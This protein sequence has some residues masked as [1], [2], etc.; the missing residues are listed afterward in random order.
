MYTIT[1]KP[2][3]PLAPKMIEVQYEK[4]YPKPE[5]PTYEMK[6]AGG[7]TIREPHTPDTLE[8]DEERKA[9]NEWQKADKDWQTGL[10]ERLLNLFI[11]SGT[12]L[13]ID[14]DTRE[15]WDETLSSLGIEIPESKT[16]RKKLYV[17]MFVLTDADKVNELSQGVLRATGVDEAELEAASKLF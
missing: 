4:A 11:L 9:Y 15:E 5:K 16:E 12:T 10:T 8:T 2:I 1:Y 13:T 6:V 14:D 7:V 17:S 3:P